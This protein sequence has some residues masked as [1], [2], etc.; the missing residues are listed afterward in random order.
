MQG[1]KELKEGPRIRESETL[2]EASSVD[3]LTKQ[4]AKGGGIAFAG[5]IAGR[6]FTLLLQILL[7][8]VLGTVSYGLY[9]LGFTV[10]GITQTISLFGLQN[11]VVRFGAMYRGEGDRARLKGTLLLAL[12]MSFGLALVVAIALYFL[13]GVIAKGVFHEPS[14]ASPLRA[15]AFALP[16]YTFVTISAFSARAFRRI[17]YDVAVSQFFRPLATLIAVGGSFLLGF[18]LMGAVYGFLFSTVI[19]AG[20]GLYLL[21]RLFPD[22]ASGVRARW[23][24]KTLLLYS[25]TVLLAGMSGLLLKRTDRIMLGILSSAKSVGIYSAAANL[26]IQAALFLTSFNAIFSPIISDLFHRGRM[27]ELEA[28]FKTTTKWIFTLTLPVVLILVL[29]ARPIMRVFGPGFSSGATVLITLAIAQ[30]VNASVGSVGFVLTMTGR[31]KIALINSL[32][33]GGLNVLLNLLLIPPYG[34]LGAA[35]ATGIS[36]ALINVTKLIEVYW[37]YKLHP[38]KASYWKPMVAGAVAVA[39][40]FGLR[41]FVEFTGWLQVGEVV[42]FGAVYG[43][44]I[45]ILGLE[46]E[47]RIIVGAIKRRLRH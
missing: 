7:T 14:L 27:R 46:V 40:C 29:F 16:F 22:I 26:A 43:A 28:L 39:F 30:V 45:L 37:L 12:G 36:I 18:R 6:F 47:D 25:G 11:G 4:I 23:E 34:V 38:Y 9:A 24:P 41:K 10:L 32:A 31:H 33:L 44:A 35:I 3:R 5:Q 2:G 1:K 21:Y 13:A 15:F 42:L 20:L 19:A 17:D 8:R